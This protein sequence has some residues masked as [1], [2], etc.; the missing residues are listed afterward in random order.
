M[1]ASCVSLLALCLAAQACAAD[2]EPAPAAR[3]GV[4]RPA[5][6]AEIAAWDIDVRGDG[7]GLPPGRGSVVEGR[8]LYATRCA[9]CHG[10][11]GEGGL[12]DPLVG[13]VGTLATAKPLRTVGSYWPFAPTVFDYVR[14]A[15]PLNAPQSLTPDQTYAVVAYVLFLNRLVPPGA[16]MDAR[17]LPRV[18][19]PN[20][21]GF[22]SPDPRPDIR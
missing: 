7:A 11:A 15:M 13:G 2:A 14:R 21:H 17:S 12:G 20:R 1:R 8:A 22:T 3:Y 19:M 16:V 4:G 5:T 6:A 10:A 9:A 18:R